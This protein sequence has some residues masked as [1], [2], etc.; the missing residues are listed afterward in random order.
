[1]YTL[2]LYPKKA[3]I[4]F[5]A[6]LAAVGPPTS[7]GR[8]PSTS[9]P[10]ANLQLP[11]VK[12]TSGAGILQLPNGSEFQTTL[13]GLKVIGLLR[14]AHKLPYYVLSGIGCNGCDAGTSIY[15]HSPSDGP[16]RD[17][18]TQP[19]FDYPG[20]EIGREDRS[21]ISET[22]MFFGNCAVGHADAVLWFYR[23]RDDNKQWQE[24]VYLAEIRDDRLAYG[25]V[26]TDVPR[27]GDAEDATR[28]S[29]CHELA[30]IDQWEE[31]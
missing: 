13:Y 26:K 22:R 14:T 15:I 19:R 17:E 30:G 21:V 24:K 23:L 1:M 12:E 5:A 16:M 31:L 18:G 8:S 6:I 29:Q 28:E 7:C 20:R 3:V 4:L 11:S 10:A 9:P 25:E 27:L 2:S